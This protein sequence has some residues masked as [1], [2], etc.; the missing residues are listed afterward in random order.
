MTDRHTKQKGRNMNGTIGRALIVVS[1]LGV[2]LAARAAAAGEDAPTVVFN[3]GF[4]DDSQMIGD[5]TPSGADPT[6]RW[7]RDKP[8]ENVVLFTRETRNPHSG[9]SS[10]RLRCL[11]WRYGG[12]S[13]GFLS[14]RFRVHKDKKYVLRFWLRGE[15]L[16]PKRAATVWVRNSAV[17]DTATL[18][19]NVRPPTW[20][21]HAERVCSLSAQWQEHV[22]NIAPEYDADVEIRLRC[23]SV[24]TIWIDDVSVSEGSF[25]REKTFELASEE[26]VPVQPS[27]EPPRK[28][29]LLCNGSFEVGTSG[30]GPLDFD[31]LDVAYNRRHFGA[32]RMNV[33]AEKTDAFHGQYALRVDATASDLVQSEY[34]RVRPGQKITLSAYMKAERE[35][36]KVSLA[37]FDGT[38]ITYMRFAGHGT[39]CD[40][41]T[42]WQ[43]FSVSGRL[44]AS[45]NNGIVVQF[46]GGKG[47]F[48]VD[49][50]QVEEGDLTPFE[51][52][53]DV[54][55]GASWQD[56]ESGIYRPGETSKVRVHALGGPNAEVNVESDLEDYYGK[57]RL[58]FKSDIRLDSDGNGFTDL[59]FQLPAPGIYRLISDAPG[60]KR[61]AERILVRVRKA[62]APRAGIHTQLFGHS[63]RFA[64][65]TG[66]GWWR[67]SD[68]FHVV[69]WK[70]AE[71]EK[72]KFVY[73]DEDLEVVL[74]TGAKILGTL[75]GYSL[76]KWVKEYDPKAPGAIAV[77]GGKAINIEDWKDYV[78]EMVR[79]YKDRIHYWEIW[80]EPRQGRVSPEH[81][82]R[83]CKEAYTVI[84]AEDPEAF[85]VGGGGLYYCRQPSDPY[86]EKLFSLGALDYMDAY[87][88]H[89]YFMGAGDPWKFGEG[90][91]EL[92]QE[93][94]KVV[95]L[96]DTEWGKQ[97]NTF[98]RISYYGGQHRGGD[99]T[100]SYRTA[101]NTSVRH[102]L[103]E[104]AL[105]VEASFWFLLDKYSPMRNNSGR[106][107]TLFE[108]DNSPRAT[109][110]ALIN[111]WDL[112]GEADLVETLSPSDIVR[113]YTFTHPEG[114]LLAVDALL[115][116]ELTA[117]LVVPLDRE[118]E[119]INV[120][121][122]R[123]F[124]RPRGGELVLA[125]SDEPLLVLFKG[126][127]PEEIARAA[128]GA[129]F[130]GMPPARVA[131]FLVIDPRNEPPR[132]L[133]GA[134]Y[135]REAPLGVG[136]AGWVFSKADGEFLVFAG[137]GPA[138]SSQTVSVSKT[139]ITICDSLGN[140][141]P[142]DNR[143][144]VIVNGA[145][146][147]AVGDDPEGSLRSARAGSQD[148]KRSR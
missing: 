98:R 106:L 16:P 43:R 27:K 37:F 23:E 146:Y 112:L 133:R 10:L 65:D 140:E 5:M 11:W 73:F 64:R 94:G 47:V 85:V 9:R 96:W 114:A 61:A 143:R 20:A 60:T 22:L 102:E 130:V 125:V 17:Q 122:E 12:S 138:G 93:N 119:Q 62:S 38:Q 32:R 52:G 110:P 88:F 36:T 28:G 134:R 75:G 6:Q 21:A 109:V 147:V 2:F 45:A 44:P 31:P 26:W 51:V 141:L 91:R 50:V 132:A 58:T 101:V 70:K 92:M 116:E 95:P 63:F 118:G 54:E 8:A 142:V 104:R 71:P 77:A 105:G 148:G 3:A 115:P 25:A 24:G 42:E 33:T 74:A 126:A 107:M 108:Y 4:E 34:I 129:R 83:L 46:W 1:V 80:N 14:P 127:Q 139:P 66:F 135:E 57:T 97:C 7:R 39:R 89:G 53:G 84:K 72:G 99:P 48:L 40:L 100:Y 117:H 78:R 121:G 69:G 124:V 41:S 76:P 19:G 30:W 113:V 82:F 55:L 111:I 68:Y 123:T 137:E 29:N 86:I 56:S 67:L 144:V 79:H 103:S 13:V 120:M 145:P 90:L 131:E 18:S 136:L 35:P 59:E 87:S 15:S 128:R 49:A 81:Y